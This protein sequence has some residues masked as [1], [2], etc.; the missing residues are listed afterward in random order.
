MWLFLGYPGVVLREM[1]IPISVLSISL[2]IFISICLYIIYIYV[3][4]PRNSVPGGSAVENLPAMQETQLLSPGQEDPLEEETAT[5]YSI[6]SEKPRG[7]RC[8]AGYSPWGSKE[9]NMTEHTH[10]C[11]AISV[12]FSCSVVSNSLQP[13]DCSTPGLPVHHQLPELTQTHAHRV[14][15]AIQPSHPLSSPS[16][17]AP[18]PSQHQGLFQ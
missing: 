13:H 15:D 5:H 16:P 18:N 12:Q 11:L 6:L 8:L 2:Y 14:G 3:H 10:T 9:L 4:M 17:P 7:Q 1:S